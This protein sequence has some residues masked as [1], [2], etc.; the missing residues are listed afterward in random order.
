MPLGAPP[1]GCASNANKPAESIH[2]GA[3][4]RVRE[5]KGLH[6]ESMA[7][8]ASRTSIARRSDNAYIL[9]CLQILRCLLCNQ[10]L[11][12]ALRQ[13]VVAYDIERHSERER[14]ES[15]I[16]SVRDIVSAR[17]KRVA[18]ASC[19]CADV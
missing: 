15:A 4:K 5:A 1:C 2:S 7:C 9:R 18:R 10:L 13:P 12:P 8:D 3:T 6:A 11:H 16:V 17:E 19:L 14:K